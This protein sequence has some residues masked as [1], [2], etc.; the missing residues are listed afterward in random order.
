[1][2][3]KITIPK[4]LPEWNA[5]GKDYFQG[6]IGLEFEMVSPSEVRASIKAAKQNLSWNGFMH[7]ASVVGIADSACAYGTVASLPTEATGFTTLE[8]KANF[9]SSITD[10]EAICIASAIHQGKSTQVWDAVVISAASRKKMALFRCTQQI[11]YP[12]N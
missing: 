11:L 10:G 1:M 4:T 5:I 2:S 3:D 12:K 9:I 7:A 8:L 6:L